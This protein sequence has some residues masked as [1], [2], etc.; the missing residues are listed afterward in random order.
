MNQVGFRCGSRLYL[1][2]NGLYYL[3]ENGMEKLPSQSSGWGRILTLGKAEMC[4]A[5]RDTIM[6]SYTLENDQLVVWH[7][8]GGKSST[9]WTNS[10]PCENL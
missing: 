8:T 3:T 6:E 1:W 10:P 5:C 2:S 9:F 7:H 4:T